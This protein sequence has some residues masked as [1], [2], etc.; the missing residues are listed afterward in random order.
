[1][2]N[3][4]KKKKVNHATQESE[5]QRNAHDLECIELPDEFLQNVV[6]GLSAGEAGQYIKTLI[7]D[8]PIKTGES[9]VAPIEKIK[10]LLARGF[11][12]D[13]DMF[14]QIMGEYY[15]GELKSIYGY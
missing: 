4:K 3:N 7:K 10:E 12:V 6:G 1:M 5:Q 9:T 8:N 14:W 15:L 13:D 2:K 11:V